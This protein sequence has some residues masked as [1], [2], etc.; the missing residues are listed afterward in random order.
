METIISLNNS[1]ISLNAKTTV[2]ASVIAQ[3][4]QSDVMG[5]IKAQMIETLK[6]KM[7]QGVAHFAFIKRDGSL[8]E[9][10]GTIQS[11]IAN[12]KTNGRGEN[13]EQYATYAFFDIE[14]GEWRSF[15]WETLVKVF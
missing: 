10:W 4:T 5:I 14:K 15:R 3:R 13:R 8:R 6:T 1:M 2:R 11:N 9:A 12:A 7:M